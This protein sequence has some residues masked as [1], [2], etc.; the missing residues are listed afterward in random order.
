MK[1]N[2]KRPVAAGL[3]LAAALGLAGAAVAAEKSA[4]PVSLPDGTKVAAEGAKFEDGKWVLPSGDPTYH[5]DAK[6]KL[7]FQTYRGF[8]RY[9][10][11][12]H[13]CHGPEG[14][15]STYAPAL[16]DSLKTLSYEDFVGVVASGRV[17]HLPGGGESVMPALGDNKNVMCYLDAIYNYLKARSDGVL[18][19]GRPKDKAEKPDEVGKAENTCLGS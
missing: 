16:A 7:D 6:G 5:I 14:V 19:R 1:T 3:M 18:E 15:G 9:H 8:Q 4:G 12:C 11:E 17:V 13:V 10:A 2:S